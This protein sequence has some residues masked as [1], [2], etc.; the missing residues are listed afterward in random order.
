MV[1]NLESRQ[2]NGF[3]SWKWLW[4]QTQVKEPRRRQAWM[5]A[6]ECKGSC[7]LQAGLLHFLAL[8]WYQTQIRQFFMRAQMSL[9]QQLR[10]Q[11]L[12]F[13]TP[14]EDTPIEVLWSENDLFSLQS[15]KVLPLASSLLWLYYMIEWDGTA[16]TPLMLR[17]SQQR[18]L[19]KEA[20][21]LRT[22]YALRYARLWAL[23]SQ[24]Q[25]SCLRS[26][27]LQSI[28]YL[29]YLPSRGLAKGCALRLISIP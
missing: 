8:E 18:W 19:Q 5:Q 20:C 1:H 6:Q 21:P 25:I 26:S 12:P 15:C 13:W 24:R 29:M 11:Y 27:C 4:S 23:A 2:W 10:G 22:E 9:L 28:L 3:Q 16:D 14:P 17:L 7:L